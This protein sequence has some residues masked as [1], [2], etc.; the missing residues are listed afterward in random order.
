MDADL[1]ILGA[2]PS[3][4]ACA[5]RAAELGLCVLLCDANPAT[6]DAATPFDKPCGEGILPAG[7]TALRALGI[8]LDAARSFTEVRYFLDGR[9]ALCIALGAPGQ[10]LWRP[11]LQRAML[12]RLR[13]HGVLETVGRASCTPLPHGGFRL[14]T[15]DAEHHARWLVAADGGSAAAAP[16]LRG[17]APRDDARR[18]RLGVRARAVERAPL[19]SVE[20][21]FGAG[22]EVYLTPLPRQAVNVVVLTADGRGGCAQEWLERGL[23]AHPLARRCLGPWLTVAEGRPLHVPWPQ[24]PSD[25]DSFITGDAGGGVDPILGAGISIAVR[26]GVAAAECAHLR[27]CGEGRETVAKRFTAIHRAERR[28]RARLAGFLHF[29]SRHGLAA[30][31][32]AAVLRAMPALGTRLGRIAGGTIEPSAAG[33]PALAR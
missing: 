12:M 18:Y 29:A 3:G 33:A 27:A 6:L 10:A 15:R 5:L 16:W 1:A 25:G 9:D 2:G 22:V 20:V 31:S 26:T 4:L 23:D 21:H 32:A 28:N 14:V 13:E 19:E 24:R 11:D 17:V 8:D 30:R 7:V